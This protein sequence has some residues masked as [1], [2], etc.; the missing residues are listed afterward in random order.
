MI[1][2]FNRD[3]TFCKKGEVPRH[4][5]LP[6]DAMLTEKRSATCLNGE[7]TGYFPGGMYTYEKVFSLDQQDIGKY[8]AIFF[9]GI[10]QH[11][12]VF[13]NEKEMAYQAYGYTEFTVDLSEE[14]KAGENKITVVV[15]NSLEPNSRW[16]SGSGIY[17]PVFLIMKE[18]NHITDV[19]IQ[20]LS[21]DPAVIEVVAQAEGAEVEIL[22]GDKLVAK[23][24]LGQFTLPHAQLWSAE[25]PH[26]YT[27]LIRTNDDEVRTDFGI[28]KIEW[29][30]RTGLLINGVETLLRG[31]CIHHDNGILGACAF[32]D[33]EERRVRILKKAGYNAIR[34]GHSPCS[35]ALLDACDRLGMYVMDEAFDGWYTPKTHHDY[36]RDFDQA[37]A[38][39]IAAMVRKDLNH[40][41]VIMYSIG[42]EVTETAE[43]RGIQ[44]TEEM[45]KLIRSLDPSRPVTCGINAMLN[46]LSAK[47]RGIYKDTS[48]YKPEPL[49]PI[50]ATKKQKES[51]SALFNAIMQKLNWLTNLM[52]GS[53]AGDAAIREAAERLDILGLNYGSSR[54]DK[55]I[56]NY[57][58]RMM[59]GSETLVS[60]LP[61]NWERV[62]KYKALIGDF[63]W[64]AWDYLGEAG[65]G[66]WTY[67]SYRGLMLAAGSGTIDLIG[68]IGAQS[69]FQQIIWGLY[70]KPYIGVRPVTHSKETAKQSRWR[71][72]NAIDSWS[73]QGYEGRRAVV[74]VFSD[75]SWIKLYLNGKLIGNKKIKKYK[76]K[77]IV[78]Y[79]PG[80]LE[81]VAYDNNKEEVSR[82]FLETSGD[83]TV[84]TVLPE[85]KS[86]YANGQDLCFV[87]IMLTDEAGVYKPARDVSIQVQVKG[88]GVLQALGSALCKTDEVFNQ[89]VHDT[90]QGHALA[91]IRAGYLPGKIRVTVSASGIPA[92]DVEIE[93]LNVVG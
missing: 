73:W 42:N 4:V 10:Y 71:F 86:L 37:Y 65:L 52:A 82:S 38:S 11:A 66:D 20:T 84:L 19:S 89:N 92:K 53:K 36:S 5:N 77:F 61:Y 30:A 12:T 27:C 1:L 49:P 39:D 90:Y 47:G 6:H 48:D 55:D 67:F 40:P 31:G 21:Y 91:V 63:V 93:V 78:K 43:A 88:A 28:R 24:P 58:N 41:S 62:R 18:K 85:K 33:A 16:Y 87:P 51:G 83:E 76:T 81:A 74:E 68:T 60:E 72:T 34:A 79:M 54:Y 22:D 26:L 13:F 45:V 25:H 29:S 59:V 7:K 50:S 75:A 17:R 2:D 23:G 56:V 80:V 3:W 32:S 9:E 57:P 70:H 14:A 44:L 15:D 35:R 46:V 8:I 64:V 69:Y